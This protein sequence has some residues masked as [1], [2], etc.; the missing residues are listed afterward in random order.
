MMMTRTLAK[1]SIRKL[2]KL[3]GFTQDQIHDWE[4]SISSPR[5]DQ[6]L[7]LGDAMD[8]I[9]TLFLFERVSLWPWWLR[10]ESAEGFGMRLRAFRKKRKISADDAARALGLKTGETVLDLERGER[11]P[12][13]DQVLRLSQLL[14]V[15]PELLGLW[16]YPEESEGP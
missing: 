13:V 6:A 11:M 9:P 7:V 3:T 4:R 12:T 15:A 8:Q 2:A 16:I 1:L 14:N 10:D 5:L